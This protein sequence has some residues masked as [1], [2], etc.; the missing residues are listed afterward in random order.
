[1][2]KKSHISL[3]KYLMNNMK[4]QD[5]QE[6]KK[7]FYIGSI[8]PDITPSFLTKR[9]NIE[10][11]FEILMD[12]IKKITVDYDI[13]KGINSY[14]ARHLGVVTHYLSDYCTF[15]HNTVFTGTFTEHCY[16][17]KELKHSLRAYVQSDSSQRVRTQLKK[18]HTIEEISHFIQ[19]THREY[20]R[21][22]KN[23]KGDIHYIIELSFKVVDAILMFF[24]LA[25]NGFENKLMLEHNLRM[26]YSQV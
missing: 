18:S 12:E 22:L 17:E 11:T 2:R 3:A 19:K 8:L 7:A 1:M 16:Y 13:N 21:A 6:H 14:Y 4:V 25:L 23:V 10:E 24:E 20:L 26:E 15:P 9:H 5:L